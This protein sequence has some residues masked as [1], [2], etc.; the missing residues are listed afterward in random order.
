MLGGLEVELDLRPGLRVNADPTL[1][2]RVVGHL[3]QNAV[4]HTPAGTPIRVETRVD[5]G[6][7][8]VVVADRGPG[9]APEDLPHLTERFYR[10]GDIN[11]RPRGLGLGLA[12]VSE[13]VAM[14]GSALEID[15][16]PA[17]GSRFAFRLEL[18]EDDAGGRRP[19]SPSERIAARRR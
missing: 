10:G 16:A 7:A 4:R 9:I 12:L 13:M 14:M 3:L 2:D 6:R 1:V 5:A 8:I 17:W 15:S 18:L 11:T 19:R